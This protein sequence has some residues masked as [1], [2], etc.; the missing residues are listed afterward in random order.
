MA[1][2]SGRHVDARYRSSAPAHRGRDGL[3]HV[4]RVRDRSPPAA[5]CILCPHQFFFTRLIPRVTLGAR[6]QRPLREAI[7]EG[8]R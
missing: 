1:A 5:E 7:L 8:S 2:C 6:H 4:T 3:D